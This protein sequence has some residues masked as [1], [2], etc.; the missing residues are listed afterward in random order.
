MN[1]TIKSLIDSVDTAQR[2]N[3]GVAF[4]QKFCQCEPEVNYYCQYCAI[5]AALKRVRNYLTNLSPLDAV[6][7][8]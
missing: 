7:R 2:A 8:S 1:N 6:V 4:E 5:Y 3:G